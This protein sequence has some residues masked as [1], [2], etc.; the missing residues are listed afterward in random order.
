MKSLI[1]R[2]LITVILAIRF[3]RLALLAVLT[4]SKI[5][6]GNYTISC[7]LSRILVVRLILRMPIMAY[8][9]KT[10]VDHGWL[11]VI[12]QG[13]LVHSRLHSFKPRQLPQLGDL[14]RGKSL[15][16]LYWTRMAPAA[17]LIFTVR[18]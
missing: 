7:V 14:F 12:L 13:H 6:N 1:L 4:K 3:I 16:S 11:R 8:R 17:G 15:L 9:C 10:F 18:G 2:V 5:S